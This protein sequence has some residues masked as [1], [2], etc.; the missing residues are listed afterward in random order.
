MDDAGEYRTR[1][2]SLRGVV[3]TAPFASASQRGRCGYGVE[4]KR[5]SWIFVSRVERVEREEMYIVY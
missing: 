3:T 4:P 1:S 2:V 5:G